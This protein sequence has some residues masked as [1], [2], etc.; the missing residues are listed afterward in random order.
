LNFGSLI[1]AELVKKPSTQILRQTFK[2]MK[3][4]IRSAVVAL[5]LVGVAQASTLTYNATHNLTSMGSSTTFTFNQFD[6]TLGTLSAID[7]IVQ[8]S[9][10]EGNLT[11]SRQT[12]ARTF[13][14]LNAALSIDPAAG[15]TGYDSTAL[16]YLR[17]PSGSFTINATSSSR[18]ITVTGTT[19]SLI[20]ASPITLSINSA[21]F[22]SYTGSSNV[23][24]D[25]FVQRGD[26]N[27]GSGVFS[28]N[29]TNLISPTTLSLRYTYSTSPGPS[30]VPEPGQ[31]A[32]SLLLLGGI[33]GY[34]FIKR[35]R[36]PATAAA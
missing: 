15:F 3:K 36:K 32:A 9:T 4:L 5:A 17:S 24:F 13:T 16:S 34:V 18:L 19:Q 1:K 31:V 25:A 6:A 22:A 27:I 33:G 11:F 8:S 7:L 2:S 14:D 26:A 30:P 10:L 21:D 12:G 29:S 35:R 20:G 23:S 28:I